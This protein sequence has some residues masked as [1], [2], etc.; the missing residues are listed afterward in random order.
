MKTEE[1]LHIFRQK[2]DFI[3]LPEYQGVDPMWRE[4]AENADKADDFQMYCRNL[5]DSLHTTVIGGSTIE[6]EDDRFYNACRVFSRGR[7][8]GRYFK[9]NPTQNEGRHGISPG[10]SPCLF[11]IDGIRISILICADVLHPQNFTRL[12]DFKPDIIFIPTTSPFKPEE[13]IR[14][15]FSRDRNIFVTGALAS[16]SYL[17]KC[18]A[19]GHLWGGHLQGRSLAVAPWGILTRI[20]PEEEDRERIFSIVLDIDELREFR[21]KYRPHH[22]RNRCRR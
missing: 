1:I 11:E 3:I 10:S 13:S 5:S 9:T 20:A 21:R 17:V 15:K 19:V 2:P 7:D 12:A 18:C 8:I 16:G 4:A 14:E 22:Q 6:S